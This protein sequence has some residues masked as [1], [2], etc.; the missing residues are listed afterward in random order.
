MA[1]F[2][3]AFEYEE[4]KQRAENLAEGT[5]YTS[6][7]GVFIEAESARAALAW[8]RE[9]SEVFCARLH[10]TEELS[11]AE[12]SYSCWIEDEPASSDWSHCLDF[13]PRV[14]AGEHPDPFAMTTEAYLAWGE[15][16]GADIQPDE[17][18]L[19]S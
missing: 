4:V 6:S 17:Q 9:I 5:R 18:S 8:G 14:A 3:F 19:D 16:T 2:L 7:T 10:T 15:E 11:W 12:R 13:F 1:E